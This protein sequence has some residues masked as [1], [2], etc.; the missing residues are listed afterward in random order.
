MPSRSLENKEYVV[1]RPSDNPMLDKYFEPRSYSF[2]QRKNYHENKH[3][4]G[5]FS[6][7]PEDSK[8][9]SNAPRQTR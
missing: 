2:D 7:A 8:Q 5:Q 3:V 9:P 1:Y 4:E 6:D